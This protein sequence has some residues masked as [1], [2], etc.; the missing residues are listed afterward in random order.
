MST[1]QNAYARTPR[2]TLDDEA[3]NVMSLQTL[4]SAAQP[5]VQVLGT[6]AGS[7]CMAAALGIWLVAGDV[8]AA[9]LAPLKVAVS[10]GLLYVG[11]HFLDAGRGEVAPEIQ[12]DL[13]GREL[14]LVEFRGKGLPPRVQRHKFSSLGA[15]EMDGRELVVED[16]EGREIVRAAVADRATQQRIEALIA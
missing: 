13:A 14:R 2:T 15:I 7:A 10:L 12:L 4:S 16:S 1:T 11:I 5:V 6:I 9:E 3:A 8:L